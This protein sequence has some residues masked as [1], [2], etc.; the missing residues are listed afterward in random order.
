[1]DTRY[2]EILWI[3]NTLDPMDTRYPEILWIRDTLRSYGYEISW[4][5]APEAASVEGLRIG[6]KDEDAGI[7]ALVTMEGSTL[8]GYQPQIAGG[9][10]DSVIP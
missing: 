2:P 7:E 6:N 10:R 9:P 1:M 3:R 8:Q 5:R 4:I